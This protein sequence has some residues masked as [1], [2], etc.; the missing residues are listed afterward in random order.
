MRLADRIKG[1]RRTYVAEAVTLFSAMNAVGSMPSAVRK[2]AINNLIVALKNCGVWSKLDRLWIAAAHTEQAA[3]LNWINPAIDPLVNVSGNNIRFNRDRGFDTFPYASGSGARLQN[4]TALGSLSNYSRDSAHFSVWSL[5]DFGTTPYATDG[6]WQLVLR[7]GG[8]AGSTNVEFTINTA[9]GTSSNASAPAGILNQIFKRGWFCINRGGDYSGQQQV[10]FNGARLGGGTVAS[11]TDYTTAKLDLCRTVNAE[12]SAASL[13]AGLTNAQITGFN[14][15][16]QTYML[17]IA[18]GCWQYY[19]TP[20]AW[21]FDWLTNPS[22]LSPE[23]FLFESMYFDRT[24]VTD[25]ESVPHYTKSFEVPFDGYRRVENLLTGTEILT[26]QTIAVVSGHNY[27]LTF[28]GT[29]S[30]IY[31]NAISGTLSG[32]GAALRV[33]AGLLSATT[34]SLTLTISG[35]VRMAQLEDVT[36]QIDSRLPAEY[37]SVGALAYPYHGPAVD[38]VQYFTTKNGNT[39]SSGVVN[40][41]TGSALDP[42]TCLKGIQTFFQ[43]QN[44]CLSSEDFSTTWVAVNAPTRSGGAANCGPI[45]LDLIGDTNA[46]ALSGYTQAITLNGSLYLP[47][48]KSVSLFV[49]QGT[50]VSSVIRLRSNGSDVVLAAITWSGGVPQVTITTGDTGMVT[51]DKVV[52]MTNGVYRIRLRGTGWSS[53][54]S[55]TIEVYPATDASL[56]AGATGTIYVGGVHVGDAHSPTPYISTTTTAVTRRA[57]SL[58]NF[59]TDSLLSWMNTA[60]LTVDF[61]WMIDSYSQ[62]YGGS[63]SQSYAFTAIKT[64]D[65][66]FHRFFLSDFTGSN[67]SNFYDQYAGNSNN[68]PITPFAL[69]TVYHGVMAIAP[70][71]FSVS[72]NG[73]ATLTDTTGTGV[74][75]GINVL[76]TGGGPNA[77]YSQIGGYA[78]MFGYLRKFGYT[79][80]RLS[81]AAIEALS[82]Q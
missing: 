41:G 53:S 73:S 45:N 82:A 13:G 3:R 20:K 1:A 32:Q 70:N 43:D 76:S 59:E 58:V 28:T 29:G 10:W 12:V 22:I 56:S 16:L 34:S 33:D 62:G 69:R 5:K 74:D 75:A 57:Q 38:G 37:V 68:I 24:T 61:S 54:G 7:P 67:Q 52:T 6:G 44:A 47:S 55:T 77:T 11:T 49:K 79:P 81:N 42:A 65:P 80:T 26:T 71:D 48:T 23:G 18:T 9:T 25:F 14:A 72:R 15:A 50:S 8:N 66:T 39:V 17:S 40:A 21:S 19:P 78:C 27:R 46:A 2:A 51:A 63:Q 31:S 60:G 30:I 4:Q 64:S 35:D 36:Y